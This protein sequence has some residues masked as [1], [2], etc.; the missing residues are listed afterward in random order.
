MDA[1]LTPMI[2]VGGL[3]VTDAKFAMMCWP[4]CW[5]QDYSPWVDE[6]DDDGEE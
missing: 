4:R 2:E 5:W 1:S 3:L 6:G